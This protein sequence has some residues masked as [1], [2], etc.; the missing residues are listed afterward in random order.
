MSGTAR[1]FFTS[2]IQRPALRLVE[3]G[4]DSTAAWL[5]FCK[6]YRAAP[7]PSGGRRP[8]PA[9][10]PPVARLLLEA[11]ED[12]VPSSKD[13][14][15]VVDS[16]LLVQAMSREAQSPLLGSTRRPPI[17]RLRRRAAR[18][19]R[20]RGPGPDRLRRRGSSRLPRATTST[21]LHGFLRS[22]NTFGV[23]PPGS[24]RHLRASAGP[25]WWYWRTGALQRC[26]RSRTRRTCAASAAFFILPRVCGGL[27]KG[28][29]CAGRARRRRRAR[30]RPGRGGGPPTWRSRQT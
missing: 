17:D 7:S 18:P 5:W 25:R 21:P 11:R 6:Q 8:R 2:M 15:L 9:C 23:R 27:G 29:A 20:H 28:L 26:G 1:F 12:A 3:G 13:A 22:W 19:R 16:S 4:L 14:F 24:D 30:P 10:A